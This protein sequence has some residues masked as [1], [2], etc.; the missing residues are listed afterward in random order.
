M[1]RV[2]LR[3]VYTKLLKVLRDQSLRLIDAS[4][5]LRSCE[6]G[7]LVT[8]GEQEEGWSD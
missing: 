2:K 6:H 4:E 1:I 3:K 5:G 8:V 7:L